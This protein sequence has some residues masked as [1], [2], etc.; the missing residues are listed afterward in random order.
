MNKKLIVTFPLFIA[1]AM[2]L[3]LIAVSAQDDMPDADIPSDEGGVAVINGEVNY[4][5]GYLPD[6]GEP[7]IVVNLTDLSNYVD[8]R[9]LDPDYVVPESGQLLGRLTSD[10]LVSPFTYSINLP[11]VP[12][13]ELRDVD[14]NGETDLG[15]AVFQVQVFVNMLGNVYWDQNGEYGTGFNST[16]IPPEFNLRN[17]IQGGTLLVWSP[18]GQQGFPVGFGDDGLLFTE[19]DPVVRLPQGYTVVNLDG[20]DGFTF[21]RSFEANIDLIEAEQSLQPSDYSEMS[22]TEAFDAL[23]A[24]MRV[25]YSFTEYKGIDWDA[26]YEEFAPRFAEAEAD[27]DPVAYQFALRDFTWAIPDGHVGAGLPLTNDAFFAET[28]GSLGIAIRELD[29]GR[30]IVNYVTEGTPAADAGIELGTEII[31]L[32]GV[33]IADAIS[34]AQPWSAPFS[35]SFSERLQQMRYAVRFE[36][37]VD[38]DVTFVN[39]DGEEETVTLTTIEERESWSFSSFTNG[40]S[41]VGSLPIEFEILDS[42]YGYIRVNRFSGD[43]LMLLRLWEWSIDTLNAQGIEGLI[44][45]LRWNSGG[46][47]IYNQMV[48]MLF[49][50][51]V[52]VGNS[53][54]YYPDVGEFVIDPLGEETIEPSPDGRY[55][56]GDV[57]AIV[58]PNCAS[59]CEFFGYELSLAG[60]SEVVGFYPSAG[61]GGNITPVYMPD[62]VYF[63]F[64]MGRSLNA[65]GDIR[66]EGIGVEPTIVVP[67]TEETLFYEG[68]IL[69]D[70]AVDFLN[71][72]TTAEVESGGEIALG[73]SVEG[74]FEAGERVQYEFTASEDI[75][76]N[77]IV[78]NDEGTEFTQRV[79]VVGNEDPAINVDQNE[80]EGIDIP[81]DLPLILEIGSVGDEEAASFTF[82]VT[83]FVPPEVSVEDGGEIAIGDSVDGELVA[84]LRIQYTLTAEEDAVIDILVGD[85]DGALDTYLRVYVDGAE[86]ATYENDDIE[87]GVINSILQGIEVTAGQSI[88]IEVAGFNDSAEGAYTL[89][90]TASEE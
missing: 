70:T 28:D 1:L 8:T 34:A 82:S 38:V 29:D 72:A 25:E 53:A 60:R 32:N 80:L 57:V 4:T 78:T 64:T 66:F 59:A 83:E 13:G 40:Q 21:D 63:Q 86:E 36:L 10:P 9:G 23:I 27:S 77:F 2:L 42:G 90:V 19:D 76:V 87:A 74:S 65:D 20:E 26:L 44:I 68:D 56:G 5:V 37:G 71:G 47:N 39:A 89:S 58:S 46:Y 41:P 67:V 88:V 16:Y 62:G 22:Y 18:D 49:D 52:V 85:A 81:A 35:T 30:V 84:G 69:L 61:L 11:I 7:A 33:P 14:N 48:S 50:E 17:E 51:T 15:V 12:T 45:D 55:Y 24:Q 54:D 43:P 3:S 79:Y 75:T 31:S 6:F 73:D